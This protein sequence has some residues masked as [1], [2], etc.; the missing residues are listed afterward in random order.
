M[1]DNDVPVQVFP[2]STP[3]V[4]AQLLVGGSTKP[5]EDLSMFLKASPNLLVATPGRLL[6]LLSSPYMHC[7]QSTF[8]VVTLLSPSGLAVHS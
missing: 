6:E 7:P 4:V 2:A 1:E 8:E 3:K 5:A